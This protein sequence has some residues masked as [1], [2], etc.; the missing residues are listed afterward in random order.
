MVYRSEKSD[1]AN[2]TQTSDRSVS[3]KAI[4]DDDSGV[5]DYRLKQRISNEN[6]INVKRK[7]GVRDSI[8]ISEDKRA[9]A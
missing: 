1:L 9:G 6:M 3:C 4:P 5:V 2:R 8:R 7:S